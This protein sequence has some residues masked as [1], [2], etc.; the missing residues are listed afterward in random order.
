MYFGNQHSPIYI[1]KI[2]DS[3]RTSHDAYD[4]KLFAGVL[5]HIIAIVIPTF[6]LKV[7]IT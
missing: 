1:S 7:A 5:E 3:Q 4:H 2:L 6:S